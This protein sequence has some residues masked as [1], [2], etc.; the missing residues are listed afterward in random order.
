MKTQYVIWNKYNPPGEYEF[1]HCSQAHATTSLRKARK[2]LTD[3]VDMHSFCE[4]KE[5]KL[6]QV[7]DM[8]IHG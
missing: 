5:W 2:E 3:V 6:L 4:P 7:L 8:E 1:L